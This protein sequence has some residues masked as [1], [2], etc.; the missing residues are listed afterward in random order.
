MVPV[1]CIIEPGTPPALPTEVPKRFLY[2]YF[3]L[4][5]TNQEQKKQTQGYCKVVQRLGWLDVG[6]LT[7]S[8]ST[9]LVTAG[10]AACVVRSGGASLFRRF[11][12]A[13][14]D[15]LQGFIRPVHVPVVT[16]SPMASWRARDMPR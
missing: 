14:D 4:C 13:D 5:H 9:V 8:P 7:A 3:A 12:V 6:C 10:W 15:K 11:G 16:E 1:R 2:L